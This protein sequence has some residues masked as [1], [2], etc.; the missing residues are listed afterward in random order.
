MRRIIATGKLNSV[1]Q[2]AFKALV[3][4]GKHSVL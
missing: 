4:K 3:R 1:E 2:A